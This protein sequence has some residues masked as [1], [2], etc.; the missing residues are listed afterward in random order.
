[1]HKYPRYD[2]SYPK[3]D[4]S[5]GNKGRLF[6]YL[7]VGS[8]NTVR[9]VGNTTNP[10][11]RENEYRNDL[12][13]KIVEKIND[14]NFRF[15]IVDRG[16]IKDR[17]YLQDY[18]VSYYRKRGDLLNKDNL[19]SNKKVREEQKKI[20]KRKVLKMKRIKHFDSHPGN[21]LSSFQKRKFK[22]NRKKFVPFRGKQQL[23]K[24]GISVFRQRLLNRC[25]KCVKHLIGI[26]ESEIGK[27]NT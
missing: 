24:S 4:K 18:W 23:S 8:D 3:L 25:R 2:S 9:Y 5:I 11:K 7:L 12:Y 26:T 15:I 16:N 27:M 10:K 21:S 19:V 20:V 14:S 1:V 22:A 17:K 13:N 6:I